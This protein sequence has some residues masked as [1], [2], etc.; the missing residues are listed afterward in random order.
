MARET[1]IIFSNE[2]RK[3]KYMVKN[4]QL[5]NGNDKFKT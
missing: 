4:F 3:M 1:I 5:I 2:K